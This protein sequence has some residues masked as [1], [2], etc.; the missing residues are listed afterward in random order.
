MN[1]PSMQSVTLSASLT[2]YRRVGFAF[3][4]QRRAQYSRLC[5][6]NKLSKVCFLSWILV[7][8]PKSFLLASP[9][10]FHY[11]VP[12]VRLIKVED[13]IRS[14]L[15]LL[16]SFYGPVSDL[17]RGALDERVTTT[18]CV[19]CRC[20]VL[21]RVWLTTPL[22]LSLGRRRVIESRRCGQFN[23]PFSHSPRAGVNDSKARVKNERL[24][25]AEI[26]REM[27][28]SMTHRLG[29]RPKSNDLK[30][31]GGM[32]KDRRRCLPSVIPLRP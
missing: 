3:P 2:S 15:K 23:H 17:R 26:E 8:H 31:K 20:L 24:K 30:N 12:R 27:K 11:C 13:V 32:Y 14:G 21:K 6:Y 7:F 28:L 16:A 25:P 1:S 4:L 5:L 19:R 29:T 22:H 9:H 10:E 18:G